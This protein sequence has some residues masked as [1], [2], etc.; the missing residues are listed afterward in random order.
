MI[1][2]IDYGLGNVM[3]FLNVYTRLN[4]PV[5]IAKSVKDLDS[6]TKLI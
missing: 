3:A 1:K 6:A 2:I 4:I 5:S